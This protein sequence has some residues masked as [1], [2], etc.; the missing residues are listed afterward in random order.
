MVKVVAV[1]VKGVRLGEDHQNAKLTN[2]EVE[3]IREPHQEGLG[4]KALATKF[5][6]SKWTIG[7]ICRYERRAETP[8]AWKTIKEGARSA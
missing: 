6:V 4:Y 1:N 7:R 5:E 3:R 8:H 2:E